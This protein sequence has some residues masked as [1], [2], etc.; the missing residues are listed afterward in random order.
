LTSCNYL[1]E[2]VFFEIFQIKK[3]IPDLSNISHISN[4]ASKI[5]IKLSL[6]SKILTVK[7]AIY[8]S[9]VFFKSEISSTFNDMSCEKTLR[10]MTF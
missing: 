10:N 2:V 1:V 8:Q 4:L 3:I 5:R 6:L 7:E 9:Y